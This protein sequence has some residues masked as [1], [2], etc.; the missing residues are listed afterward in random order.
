M[1]PTEKVKQIE[2]AQL[3]A[4]SL[5]CKPVCLLGPLVT[6]LDSFSPCLLRRRIGCIFDSSEHW[7]CSAHWVKNILNFSTRASCFKQALVVMAGEFFHAFFDML[8]K[9]HVA[10]NLRLNASYNSEHRTEPR[11]EKWNISI[12]KTTACLMQRWVCSTHTYDSFMPNKTLFDPSW[13]VPCIM[14][15]T[16]V[17]INWNSMSNSIDRILSSNYIC[18]YGYCWLS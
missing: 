3:L 9:K 15:F 11:M 6:E 17:Y 14:V 10:H 18:L 2:S 4:N 1:C 12:Y 16:H 8:S 7:A 5:S 13:H